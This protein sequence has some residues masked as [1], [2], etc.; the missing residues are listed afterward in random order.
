ITDT[1][2]ASA[3]SSIMIRVVMDPR[4]TAFTTPSNI[5]TGQQLQLRVSGQGG[6]G[7]LSYFYTGLPPG[8]VSMNSPS[9]SCSPTSSGSYRVTATI[10]D[11][12][13]MTDTTYT[14]ITVTQPI[15]GFAPAI[16]YAV[17]AG[18][19]IAAGTG[20]TIAGMLIRQKRRIAPTQ[21]PLLPSL[22]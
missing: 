9:I 2:S 11:A 15:L 19:A 21:K 18:I 10:T 3:S 8:C 5:L 17:I 14:D 20:A 16:G 1:T 12:S 6:T 13:G 4:I 7:T 22:A